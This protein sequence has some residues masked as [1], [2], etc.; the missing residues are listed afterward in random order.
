[1]GVSIAASSLV[2]CV[3]TFVDWVREQ[4]ASG[5]CKVLG[6]N[7]TTSASLAAFANGALAH[8]LDFEDAHDKALVHPNAAV[9]PAAI[10]LA[11]SLNDVSGKELLL[12]IV[13]GCEITCRWGYA[14]ASVMDQ[15]HWYPPPILSAYGATA[16]AAKL[17][18]LN[19]QQLLDA[20]SLTLSQATC[21]AEIKHN[22]QSHIRAVRDAFP[23]QAGVVSAQL[24]GKG[25]AGFAQPLEGKDGF[26]AAFTRGDSD[27]TCLT[28]NLGTSFAIDELSFK[29]WPSCRGTHVPM[30][31]TKNLIEKHGV[32][33][34]DIESVSVYGNQL[35]R[36]LSEP[37]DSKRK[38]ATA[39]DAKFSIPFCV[40][41]MIVHGDV[42]LSSFSQKKLTDEAIT[43]MAHK[44]NYLVDIDFTSPLMAKI[45]MFLTDGRT[46]QS[47]AS[48][49]LGCPQRPL[50]EN[51]LVDKFT[52]CIGYSANRG[53]TDQAQDFA[54]L[55]LSLDEQENLE[56]L[57]SY[58]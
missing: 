9:I 22:S 3:Q 49:A 50:S 16:A 6:Q 23:A 52:H 58:L 38:P 34:S 10:A 19:E 48:N 45:E 32:R 14:V 31:L 54:T 39:I 37:L 20:W 15:S 7:F 46:L 21:S 47:H 56:T 30:E 36:M 24:A 26:L 13:V 33:A 2:E 4:N 40:A 18:K 11:Q 53:N 44:V 41:S 43:A 29:P 27:H 51:Q 25:V 17:L 35:N 5:P 1:M 12:A 55:L 8:A 42:D 28:E 57:F